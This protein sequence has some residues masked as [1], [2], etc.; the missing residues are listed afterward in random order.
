MYAYKQQ[1]LSSVIEEDLVHLVC[2]VCF[3][4]GGVVYLIVIEVN[5]FQFKSQLLACSGF[6]K[7]ANQESRN[8]K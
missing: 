4:S 6:D 5:M 2:V 8:P 3:L 7:N 1:T